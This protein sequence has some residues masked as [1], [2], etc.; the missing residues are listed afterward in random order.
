MR[1]ILHDPSDLLRLRELVGRERNAKQRDRYRVVLLAAEGLGGRE[2]KREQIAAAVGRSR[3]FVDEWVKRYRRGGIEALRAKK[4]PGRTPFLSPGQKHE[5][6]EALDAGPRAGVDPRSTFFAED[7]RGLIARRFG[8]LYSLS[9]VYNLL[10]SM[11]FG[12]LCP[13]PRH[14]GGYAAAPP[15]EQEAMKKKSPTTWRRRERTLSPP[16]PA[17]AC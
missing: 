3:Q 8:K 14:P 1:V 13:R 7:I 17:N 4:Q 6:G 11:G 15:A 5:L 9:G 2:L 16:T 10:D 12:W